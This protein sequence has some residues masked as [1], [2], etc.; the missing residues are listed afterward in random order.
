MSVSKT[1]VYLDAA[2]YRQLK[3]LADAEGKKTAALVREA[4]A[5][6]IVQRGGLARP[7]SVGAGRSGRGDVAAS[8]EKLLAGMGRTPRK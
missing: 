5:A 7:S 8:A 6:Y 1:T 4:V 3:R 2:E